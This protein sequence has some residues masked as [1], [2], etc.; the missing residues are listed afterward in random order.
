MRQ[1]SR[2]I[3]RSPRRYSDREAELRLKELNIVGFALLLYGAAV[4]ADAVLN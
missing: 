3:P 1:V 4:I 2:F